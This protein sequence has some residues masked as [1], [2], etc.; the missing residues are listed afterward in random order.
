MHKGQ[1]P[2]FGWSPATLAS[3]QPSTI[4][5]FPTP[6]TFFFFYQTYPCCPPVDRAQGRGSRVSPLPR[7]SPA[8]LP[9]PNFFSNSLQCVPLLFTVRTGTGTA[10]RGPPAVHC[11]HRHRDSRPW[12]WVWPSPGGRPWHNR[13]LA[14]GRWHPPSNWSLLFFHHRIEG[15]PRGFLQFDQP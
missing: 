1:H 4:G 8:I 9:V 2:W 5:D 12:F 15:N 11:A 3:V 7:W 6:Y 13:L 10:G 14:S